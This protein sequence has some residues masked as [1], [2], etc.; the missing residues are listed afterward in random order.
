[1]LVSSDED[2]VSTEEDSDDNYMIVI[3]KILGSENSSII[4]DNSLISQPTLHFPFLL[5]L[6]PPL[7]S[8]APYLHLIL[9][10]FHPLFKHHYHLHQ[11]YQFLSVL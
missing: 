11:E 6:L 1:M 9:L 10:L 3:T 4:N 7:S 2:N 8:P 5:L